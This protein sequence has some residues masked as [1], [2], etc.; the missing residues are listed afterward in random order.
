MLLLR[1][2]FGRVGG[3]EEHLNLLHDDVRWTSDGMREGCEPIGEDV[4]RALTK[5]DYYGER[6][7]DRVD[8][9]LVRRCG[10]GST[11]VPREPR[12]SLSLKCPK[13]GLRRAARRGVCC[14][15]IIDG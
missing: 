9:V 10:S 5:Q 6:T 8:P 11:R 1:V 15:A 2:G 4:R 7:C 12:A 14:H 3:I 13:I